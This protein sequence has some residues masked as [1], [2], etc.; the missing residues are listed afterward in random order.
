VDFRHIIDD[1]VTD[2]DDADRLT[3]RTLHHEETAYGQ[4]NSDKA[5]ALSA[6]ATLTRRGVPYQEL[7][8]VSVAASRPGELTD[9]DVVVRQ[10]VG[11]AALTLCQALE[12][13]DVYLLG[14]NEH[15]IGSLALFLHSPKNRLQCQLD[16]W[17]DPSGRNRYKIKTD[18]LF[19]LLSDPDTRA[20]GLAAYRAA[21]A[22]DKAAPAPTQARLQSELQAAADALPKGQNLLATLKRDGGNVATS[23]AR[24][25]RVIRKVRHP[26]GT[27]LIVP[28]ASV[29][30]V[31][32][33][34]EAV[35]MPVDSGPSIT[36]ALSALPRGH[37]TL[38]TASSR[39]ALPGAT[40]RARPEDWFRQL[41]HTLLLRLGRS[42]P[43]HGVIPSVEQR[44]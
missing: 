31:R 6:L 9:V 24:A 19:A 36:A 22:A 38:A 11:S 41:H 28:A 20:L 15:D 43:L 32:A 1:T 7:G 12:A 4:M 17:C 13:S 44:G 39:L 18:E 30:C 8:R 16:L 37:L 40:C 27:I 23:Y 21:K 29:D 33:H 2:Q 10:S 3:G 35:G 42:R 5:L 14:Y 26:G 25:K 34:L